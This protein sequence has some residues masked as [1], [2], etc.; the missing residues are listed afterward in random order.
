ML[1]KNKWRVSI[2]AMTVTSF[3]FPAAAQS[4][5]TMPD[6]NGKKETVRICSACHNLETV[7]TER[8]DK[9]GWQTVVDD[10][11][12]R[13]ADGTDEELKMV[14]EYLSKYFGPKTGSSN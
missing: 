8:H 7:T 4:G 9:A 11:V 13:G 6:G 14:V 1:V 2:L 10:M 5:S 3:C 12:S